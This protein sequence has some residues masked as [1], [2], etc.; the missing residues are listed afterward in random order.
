MDTPSSKRIKV[1]TVKPEEDTKKPLSKIKEDL[2]HYR[3]MFSGP[4]VYSED[5]KHKNPQDSKAID[6][7][8]K[9]V[10]PKRY[11]LCLSQL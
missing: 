3:T 8:N 5:L 4:E 7:E 11:I 6:W 9:G 1:V 2:E 10:V